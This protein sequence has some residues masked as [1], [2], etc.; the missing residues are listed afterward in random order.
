MKKLIIV[1]HAKSDW[2]YQGLKDIHRPLNERG[3]TDAYFLSQQLAKK[4]DCPSLWLTSP[5]IRAY[6]TALIFAHAF[7]LPKEKIILKEKIYEASVKNLASVVSSLPDKN[8]TAILF[9]HNP[10]LTDFINAYS[11]TTL[12][13]LPTCGIHCL[14]GDAD[15]WSEFLNTTLKNDFYLYPKDFRD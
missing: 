14:S 6:S 13:N 11:Q 12:E 8:N 15:K 2:G 5:A 4:I 7:K 10:G 9:G 1:R 3:Y